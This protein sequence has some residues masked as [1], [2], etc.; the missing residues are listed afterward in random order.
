[1]ADEI[2]PIIIVPALF[3]LIGYCIK[4]VSD[5]RAKRLLISQNMSTEMVEKLFLERQLPDTDSA[6]KWG[7]IIA[8]IGIAFCV[9]QILNVDVHEPIAYGVIFLF[10]GASLLVYYA[11]MVNKQDE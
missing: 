7:L 10:G 2:I 9:L 11:L 8:S 5:N 3:F 4:V 1:M 6:L